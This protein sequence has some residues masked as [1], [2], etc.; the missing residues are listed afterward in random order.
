MALRVTPSEAKG[1][2]SELPQLESLEQELRE[3]LAGMPAR[4]TE[5][6]TARAW[7]DAERTLR[8][9]RCQRTV[10]Q[11]W[12]ELMR[13]HEENL[14]RLLL[15]A[16]LNE[17]LEGRRGGWSD[18]ERSDGVASDPERSEGVPT[19]SAGLPEL[20]ERRAMCSARPDAA[21][22]SGATPSA[23]MALRVTPSEAK[24]S[25]LR[26][27]RD[28]H[29]RCLM[30][31]RLMGNDLR[32]GDRLCRLHEEAHRAGVGSDPFRTMRM[33]IDFYRGSLCVIDRQGNSPSL[34]LGESDQR[35]K[36]PS[37]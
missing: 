15:L 17:R 28:S 35:G 33:V 12:A 24:G 16:A 27:Q 6:A 19:A 13:G 26:A 2:S 1:S 20:G 30:H 37:H 5:G 22:G 29:R 34:A 9:L 36:P 14:L 23:A 4:T 3:L 32:V 25:A 11:E 21:N 10:F 7:A 18:A 8:A 31:A